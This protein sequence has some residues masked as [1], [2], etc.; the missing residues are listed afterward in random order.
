MYKEMSKVKAILFIVTCWLT[1]FGVMWQAGELTVANN[2][3][4][5]FPKDADLITA[6]L[7]LPTLFT[8]GASV[9][10]GALLRKLST[11]TELIIAGIA[12]AFMIIAPIPQSMPFLLL[13]NIIAAIGAGFANTAGMS[14]ISEV[15]LDEKLRSKHMGL[16]NAMMALIGAL[17][18][19]VAG[20][21]AVNNWSGAFLVNWITVPA[22]VMSIL[23]LPN[24]KPSERVEEGYGETGEVIAGEKKGLGS[25][26]W[27]FFASTFLFMISYVPVSTLV[28]VYVA[29][30]NFGTTAFAGTC[31]SLGTVGSFC[32]GLLF[33]AIYGK[34]NRKLVIFVTAFDVVL[35][36]LAIFVS[37][38]VLA[39]VLCLLLGASYGLVFNLIFAYA[40]EIVPMSQ[41][42]M[43]MGL[44]TLSSSLAVTIGVYLF[45]YLIG[46]MGSLTAS[47]W[48]SLGL[49]AV[50]FVIEIIVGSAE[51]RK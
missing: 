13:C 15:F 19:F 9:V 3:Y 32:M 40:A 16:Y 35:Y 20:V 25:K 23:F 14:I 1:S 50:V 45:Q 37:S 46:V 27:I 18:G 44:M 30:N 49:C 22:L 12:G 8:A 29:E 41:N 7:S 43:A 11:K 39:L 33:G 10:A 24:I 26:F 42:G 17:C 2:L 5:L 28:S 51:K 48:I 6:M 31:S 38:P 4:E 34:F 36:L 21:A 47:L